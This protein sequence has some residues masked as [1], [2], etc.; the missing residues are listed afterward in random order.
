MSDPRHAAIPTL[1]RIKPG[2]LSRVGIYCRRHGFPTTALWFSD[3]LDP[4]IIATA[5]RSLASEQI[6]ITSRRAVASIEQTD[7]ESAAV[8][9]GL[10]IGLGGGK[11][12]DA[13]K[14]AA[15]W[16]G[17]PYLAVPTSL[18][19]DGFASPQA[20][21]TVQGRR[22]SVPASMPFGVVID[23]AVCLGAPPVLWLSGIGDLSAKLTAVTDWKLAFHAVGT[24]V[25][26]FAALLADASFYQLLA[27]PERDLDGIRLL[28]SALLI[29]GIAMSICGSSRP[30]SGSEHLISH[31]FDLIATR[32][33]LHGLQVA[34]ATAIC[35]RLQNHAP[36]VLDELFEKTGLWNALRDDPF[37]L[38]EWLE[39][40][41]LAPTL[42]ENFYTVLSSRNC[43]PEIEEMISTDPAFQDLFSKE[44]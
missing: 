35:C 2:A 31:A 41:R 8:G 23:T 28:A 37:P 36:T 9:E 42:K 1:V 5:E 27:R 21:V 13:A 32:P 22:R 44:S 39:A 4:R 18:S 6:E 16:R 30:A 33:R 17:R 25:D 3:G 19:N 10:L 26:D 20:S 43:L 12:L 7:I 15:H 34:L 14:L 29:N 11:A 24:P 38:S 40:C